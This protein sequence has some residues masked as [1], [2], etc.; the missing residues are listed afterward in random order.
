MSEGWCSSLSQ[1]CP[2]LSVGRCGISY[3]N[4]HEQDLILL[5][6]GKKNLW[7][8]HCR[9]FQLERLSRLLERHSRMLS[10]KNLHNSKKIVHSSF[11]LFSRP[12][13]HGRRLVRL[14]VTELPKVNSNVMLDLSGEQTEGR[15]CFIVLS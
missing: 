12:H 15:L 7:P 6:W 3:G 9:R 1:N 8:F 11:L 14:L 4:R 13:L 5:F 2:K 10:R